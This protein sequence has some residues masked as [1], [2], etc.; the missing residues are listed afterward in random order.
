MWMGGV[1]TRFA[2]LEE[3]AVLTGTVR[4]LMMVHGIQIDIGAEMDG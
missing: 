3:G 2:D 1:Q 4:R